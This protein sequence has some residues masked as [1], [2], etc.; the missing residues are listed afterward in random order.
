[1]RILRVTMGYPTKDVPGSGLNAYYHMAYSAEEDLIIT[2]GKNSELIPCRHGKVIQVP[3]KVNELGKVNSR[4]ILSAKKNLDKVLSQYFFFRRARKYVDDF[5]PDVVHIYTPIPIFFGKYC[6]KKFGSLYVMSLHGTDAERI[7]KEKAYKFMLQ[8]PD[9]VLS[10]GEGMIEKLKNI[11]TKRPIICI[12]NGVDTDSFSN[13][14]LKREKRLIQVGSFRWQKDKETLVKAFSRFANEF[15][16][17]RLVLV[18]DGEDRE[19][20]ENLA[21]ELNIYD[22]IDFAGIRSRD[23]IVQLLNTSE[24]FVL[25]SV[26]EGF[27]K[28]IYEAMAAGTPVLSTD[29]VNVGQVIKD[30]GIVVP[31]RD[32]DALYA[33]MK[34]IVDKDKWNDRSQKAALY[35]QEHTWQSVSDKLTAIY[36]GE[37]K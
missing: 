20:I 12:G 29:I 25:S 21:K 31:V 26:S 15:P 18:G 9:I 30:S 7:S 32:V 19:H 22:R 17:Y 2:G 3:I 34:E 35:A 4:H 6:R 36:K 1:M 8:A 33:G 37:M 5:K 13:L 11:K 10:V 16:E 23:E 14:H 24:A 28:V 27:P